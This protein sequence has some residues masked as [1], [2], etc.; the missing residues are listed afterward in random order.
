MFGNLVCYA[1]I[2]TYFILLLEVCLFFQNSIVLFEP[3]H[4]F[5]ARSLNPLWSNLWILL[6]T[7][8]QCYII[9][10]FPSIGPWMVYAPHPYFTVMFS[11]TRFSCIAFFNFHSF[12]PLIFLFLVSYIYFLPLKIVSNYTC[13]HLWIFFL[14]SVIISSSPQRA[15][16][17]QRT[18]IKKSKFQSCLW[19]SW[20]SAI[21]LSLWM[22]KS[23]WRYDYKWV[24]VWKQSVYRIWDV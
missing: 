8:T 13:L 3:F 17:W 19:I 23:L 5:E 4:C 22:M 24:W 18:Q 14:F 20:S 11:Y 15:I 16:M 9:P 21:V 12:N 2:L 6:T 1:Q 7:G 10:T